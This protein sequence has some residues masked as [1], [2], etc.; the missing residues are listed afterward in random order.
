MV[1]FIPKAYA[2][3]S[4]FV[5]T[6]ANCEFTIMLFLKSTIGSVLVIAIP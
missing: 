5:P 3:A 2:L 1:L 4:G 6:V